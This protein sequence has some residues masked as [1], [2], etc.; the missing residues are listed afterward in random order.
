MTNTLDAP[1]TSV[2]SPPIAPPTAKQARRP[3]GT[4]AAVAFL[5][6]LAFNVFFAK[7]LPYIY[8]EGT[9]LKVGGKAVGYGLGPGSRAWF[10]TD[11]SSFD[12]FARSMHGGG[13]TLKIGVGATAIGLLLG[14]T[15]GILGGYFQG[16]TDRVTSIIVDTLLALPPLLLAILLVYRF[17]DLR[18]NV[19]FLNWMTKTWQI[20]ITLG[21]LATAPLARI[22]RAQ[23]LALRDREFVLA[24]RSVGAK[25]GRVIFR[26]IF[27]NL[28]PA[29]ITVAFTGLGIL[30]TAETAL[31]FVGLGVT[32][33]PTW[34]K[35]IELGR[36]DM[37]KG[38]WATIFPCL[39]LFFTVLSFNVIGDWMARKFDI[40]EAAI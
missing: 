27:P 12:V 1:T 5:V 22:V 36:K 2:E 9:K 10:G 32:N 35:L 8:N 14:G 21:L 23:T 15:L 25:G 40:R 19:G 24:A 11:K 33:P 3:W 7:W 26:E 16:W 18:R 30:I 31:A 39:L 20:T 38:W 13:A 34:G 4:I 29:M 6:L 17:E 28:V 37:S